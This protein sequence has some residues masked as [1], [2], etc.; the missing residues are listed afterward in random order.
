MFL[1]ALLL[2]CAFPPSSAKGRLREF[3]I[4]HYRS[5]IKS[6]VEECTRN[7]T[8]LVTV[9][10]REDDIELSTQ[11]DKLFKRNVIESPT[12]WIGAYLGRC[13][14]K[15]SN[16]DE[17]NE[18][19]TKNI[20]KDCANECCAT[21]LTNGDWYLNTCN[22]S[23]PFL[24]YEQEAGRASYNYVYIDVKKTWFEAQLYCREK[25]VDLVSI[26]NEKE[27]EQVKIKLQKTCW[28]G[29][30][31]DGVKWSDEGQ[32]AYR[33][34]T[35]EDLPNKGHVYMSAFA[36]W[37][38]DIQES[39]KFYPICYKS[40]IYVSPGHMSWEKAL[41]H[42]NTQ[43]N[44]AGLLRIE[45]ED[46]QIETERELKRQKISGPVWIGLRQSRLFG[47]WIWSNG[48]QLGPWTNWKEGS[49]PE[50]QISEH[51]GAM[52]KIWRA[53]DALQ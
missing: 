42:C 25:H 18:N 48:L 16:G 35:N 24:C 51:C 40:F 30:L 50:H 8:N 10:D 32:S 36:N 6:A 41:D 14:K 47:F 29:L 31:E 7:Y 2:L 33:K 20:K 4:L 52:E 49:A 12:G 3:H 38:V 23:K 53:M 1:H 19:I 44:T 34:W 46:D 9:Y 43:N 21:M 11:L 5:L 27:N 28:I 17:V 22:L 26:R 45:S 13:S 37:T 15:W 39:N